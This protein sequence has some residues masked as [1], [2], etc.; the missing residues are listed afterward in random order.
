MREKLRAAFLVLLAS[1]LSGGCAG[2]PRDLPRTPSTAVPATA[3]T[4]L[5]RIAFAAAG[6]KD[7][8]QSG[9]R[10]IS[11]PEQ[12]F[13]A[14]LAL[15]AR[16]QRTLDLQYYVF[17]DDG[18]GRALARALRDAAARGVRVRLLLDDLY[19]GGHDA[20]FLGLAAH[21]NVEVG[22]FNPFMVRFESVG[23]RVAASLFDFGRLN[24]RMH[25]KL[26]IADGAMAM[27]GGRNI[28]DEYFMAHQG[29]NYIDLDVF[30]AGAVLPT[31]QRL[32][33]MYWNSE[34]VYPLESIVAP[35][36]PAE[37]RRRRF[38]QATRGPGGPALPKPGSTDQIG[39]IGIAEQLDR[40]GL[41]L[42]WG[43]A[44]AFADSPDKV[45]GHSQRVLGKPV[46][47][48]PTVRQSLMT[49]L[50]LAR[51]HVFISSPYLVP[52]RS[53]LEDIASGRLWNLS[54]SVIT[55]SLASTDEPLVHAGYQRYRTE[56][57]DLGV[58]LYEV[59]PSRIQ[60]S[61]TLGS[62][63][64]KS[65][66]RFHAKTAAIDGERMF[67]GSLNFDPR[68]EKH[69][70]ELG[71][72]IHSPELTGQLLTLAELV[73]NEASYRVRLGPD[74]KTLEWHLRTD[75]GEQ[76]FTEEP[77]TSWWQRTMLQLVGPFVPEGQL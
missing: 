44:Q 2:L 67:I 35:S 76:V 45:I 20:L 60:R 48:D 58:R 36:E 39:Q 69:N 12:S 59:A 29:S 30:A 54:I 16:A 42:I 51:R 62:F 43:R 3:D 74:R 17:E 31:L 40:G 26:F 6:G 73:I 5:G 38:E 1:V 23:A 22:L 52:D 61:K 34:H 64:G 70:T 33:D 66:G 57:L 71:F 28:G 32:F 27:A 13:A 19:S 21:P 72:L 55:N 68:S 7:P 53:V 25:N 24:H 10:L 47:A 37:E 18:T 46:Q 14:R 77:D 4:E 65:I 63:F 9:F 75:Q 49:E 50:L 8:A 11:W 56:M 41:D 15:V